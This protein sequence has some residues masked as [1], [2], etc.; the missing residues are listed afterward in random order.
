MCLNQHV[1]EWTLKRLHLGW[2][3]SI[4]LYYLSI[5]CE[6]PDEEAVE[7]VVVVAVITLGCQWWCGGARLVVAR[8]PVVAWSQCTLVLVQA[9]AGVACAQLGSVACRVNTLGTARYQP[10]RETGLVKNILSSCKLT[11]AAKHVAGFIVTC[12]VSIFYK[13]YESFQ[14]FL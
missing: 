9:G 8:C 14:K 11:A 12:T 4:S 2:F 3:I 7:V 6:C 13:H 5:G 1:K 10:V